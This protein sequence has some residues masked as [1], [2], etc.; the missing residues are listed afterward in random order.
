[1][2]YYPVLLDI[3]G[4]PCVVIGGGKVAERKAVGLIEAGA[5][6]T[7][8]SPKATRKLKDL[9]QKGAIEHIKRG[10]RKGD[11]SGAFLAVSAADSKAVNASACMEASRSN[12]L[13][14]AVDDPGNCNFIIPSSFRRGPLVIAVSTSGKSPLL[15]RALRE[16][17]EEEIG[18]EYAVFT[19]LL[20][21][22][23]ERLLKR[24]VENGKKER[25]IKA[26]IKSPILRFIREGSLKE[27]DFL[28]SR[29]LGNGV[30]LRRL[31]IR[32]KTQDAAA[33]GGLMNRR[34]LFIFS[35]GKF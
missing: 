17:L 1:M 20:G 16:A 31:G 28:L 12:I 4:R 3:E 8:I 23:R 24:G 32:T 2:R 34:R 5:L 33:G 27:I 13:L 22:I 25:I 7:V 35:G 30:T 10:Y 21:A 29:L 26:L 15:A 19:E 9:A 6:V 11:L 18:R 14:N